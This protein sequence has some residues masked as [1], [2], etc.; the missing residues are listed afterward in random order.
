[1]SVLFKTLSGRLFDDTSP[2]SGIGHSRERAHSGSDT[3]ESG[4]A[5]VKE[6]SVDLQAL[7]SLLSDCGATTVSH[8][9]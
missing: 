5:E 9:R 7:K 1:M 3:F 2:D 8:L 6:S 4:E